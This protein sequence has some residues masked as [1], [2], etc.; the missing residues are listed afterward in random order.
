MTA[1]SVGIVF[2]LSL[3]AADPA[4]PLAEARRLLTIEAYP[5]SIA[6][7]KDALSMAIAAQLPPASIATIRCELG[8]TLAGA[9]EPSGVIEMSNALAVLRASGQPTAIADCAQFLARHLR[10]NGRF[11]E[12][13]ELFLEAVAIEDKAGRDGALAIVLLNLTRLEFSAGSRE[14]LEYCVRRLQHLLGTNPGRIPEQLVLPVYTTLA[15]SSRY[16]YRPED[17]I[18]YA[19]R[20][21]E[22]GNTAGDSR[23][24]MRSLSVLAATNVELTRLGKA[25][26]WARRLEDLRAAH[27]AA[28]ADFDLEMLVALGYVAY[29]RGELEKAARLLEEARGLTGKLKHADPITVSTVWTHLGRVRR[30]Q[31]NYPASEECHR[32]ALAAVAALP[33]HHYVRA[34]AWLDLADTYRLMKRHADAIAYYRKGLTLAGEFLGTGHADLA[35]DYQNFAAVLRKTRNKR[36][37]REYEALARLALS[38]RPRGLT[39]DI[40]QWGTNPTAGRPVR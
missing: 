23:E 35:N 39:V 5:E 22:L 37:A 12:S 13:R 36:E 33:E 24:L 17:A 40:E 6:A 1:L 14:G 31:K 34:F 7:Y 16:L 10:T 30:F 21:V 20:A 32:N 27:P 18:R 4:R 15:L 11:R 29:Q 25:G 26:E 28:D 2:S 8:Y 3:A 9:G 38:A 19:G